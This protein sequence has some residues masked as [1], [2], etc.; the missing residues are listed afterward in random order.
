[1]HQ[2]PMAP[3]SPP[4]TFHP[5]PLPLA[6][7]TALERWAIR[8]ECYGTPG[9]PAILVCPALGEGCHAAGVLAESVRDSLAP[10][11][12]LQG[13]TG[14][15][16]TLIGPGLPLDTERYFVIVPS[17]L[18]NCL[19][20]T[21][22]VSLDE[23]AA[24]VKGPPWHHLSITDIATAHALLLEHL[25]I[26]R[27]MFAG[28]SLGGMA[29]IELALLEPRRCA[30]LLVFAAPTSQTAWASE[31]LEL[32]EGIVACDPD[33]VRS[34][35]SPPATA[36]CHAVHTLFLVN[37]TRHEYVER[38]AKQAFA[39]AGSLR[40]AALRFAQRIEVR[41]FRLQLDAARHYG[42]APDRADQLA[43]LRQLDIPKHFVGYTTDNLYG[44]DDIIASAQAIGAQ[45][46]I[47]STMYGHTGFL[48]DVPATAATLRSFLDELDAS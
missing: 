8:Y 40:Q 9:H 36:Y 42:T 34:C 15:W 12:R 24:L 21:G 30:G 5:P 19:G 33:P 11:E 2:Q 27:A 32:L 48:L 17:P 13:R 14:W 41:G 22:P 20:T 29:A 37:H 43:V 39:D 38:A 47:V 18:G 44:P 23:G 10:W 46:E 35:G 7:G 26:E 45:H 28:G 4:R 25:G 6:S 16:H 31:I 3:G 1:M